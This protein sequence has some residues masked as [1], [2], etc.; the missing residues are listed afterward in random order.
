MMAAEISFYNALIKHDDNQDDRA[1]CIGNIA[2]RRMSSSIL[3][4]DA[5]ERPNKNERVNRVFIFSEK[6]NGQNCRHQQHDEGPGL[7]CNAKVVPANKFQIIADIR[8]GCNA[9][10]AEVDGKGE[11]FPERWLLLFDGMVKGDERKK[12]ANH[13]DYREQEEFIMP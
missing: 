10:P 2:D 5:N 3:Y 11:D 7:V 6:S 9:D 4:A 1:Q 8:D 12:Q 13:Y